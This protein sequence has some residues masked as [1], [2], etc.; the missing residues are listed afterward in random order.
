MK[1]ISYNSDSISK[2]KTDNGVLKI[3]QK[4]FI[5]I[6]KEVEP[7][8]AIANNRRRLRQS[9][10]IIEEIQNTVIRSSTWCKNQ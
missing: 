2:I 4:A 8:I 3:N 7:L 1:L 5:E 6:L 10:S 9:H